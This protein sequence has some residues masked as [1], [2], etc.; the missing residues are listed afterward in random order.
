MKEL[1]AFIN[2]YANNY[3]NNYKDST[4]VAGYANGYVAIP[5]EHPYYGRDCNEINVD[6][7]GDLTFSDFG[8]FF[9][10]SKTIEF[11]NGSLK[12]IEDYWVLGF[13]TCHFGDN[14][15]NW[16]REAVI[17]ETLKLKKI[18]ENL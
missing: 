7:H 5:K 13:D 9:R 18:L 15:E 16:P 14:L 4:L 11:I 10:E 12:D 8:K 3:Y 2:S 6:V 1:I 17:E